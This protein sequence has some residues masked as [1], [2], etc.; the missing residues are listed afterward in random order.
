MDTKTKPDAK[1]VIRVL[2]L[3]Q[4]AIKSLMGELGRK[5]PATDWATVND[6]LCDSAKLIQDLK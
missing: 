6:A 3:Q 4:E 1:E 5:G 2:K